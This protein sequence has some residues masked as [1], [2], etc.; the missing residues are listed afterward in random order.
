VEVLV[1]LAY[2]A[3][4]LVAVPIAVFAVQ[5]IA[6][7]LPG[8]PKDESHLGSPQSAASAKVLIPAHDEERVLERTLV[9]LFSGSDL[10]RDDVLVVAHNCSDRT[11][12][13]ARAHQVG[14]LE[15][16]DGGE[17]GKPR[18]LAAGLASFADDP[19]DVVVTLDA[20][21]TIEGGA[22]ELLA[23]AAH[24]HQR[25]VQGAY[26]FAGSVEGVSLGAVSELALLFKNY[27]RPLGLHRLGLPCLLNGS[28]SAFP[29]SLLREALRTEGGI[30]ED[31]VYSIDLALAG[32]PTRFCP[33]A[34]VFSS[35]PEGRDSALTQ[36]RR[37]EHGNL[38]VLLAKGPRL[39]AKG[40]FGARPALVSLGLDLFVPPLALLALAWFGG[41]VLT[42]AAAGLGGAGGPLGITVVSGALLVGTVVAGSVRFQGAAKTASLLVAIPAYVLW[43]V[44]LYAAY[45]LRREQRWIRT[46]REPGGTTRP[47][48][49]A[50]EG[51]GDGGDASPRERG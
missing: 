44:P 41:A 25:P 14:V 50:R 10:E 8:S 20:D 18:A 33:S 21:C 30:V 26:L 15:V 1:W 7:V 13:I 24:H 36:R 35:L 29:Y 23:S 34:F 16:E 38:S 51:T 39:L 40:L 32:Y 28:G 12:Q 5:G 37:W 42:G 43:K 46:S 27:V 31:R 9:S 45:I 17:G 4:C 49:G 6:A 47:E 48:D 22:I 3:A 11:S 19:P 2:A